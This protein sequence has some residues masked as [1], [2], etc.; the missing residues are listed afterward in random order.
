M[1]KIDFDRKK[2]KAL[3]SGDKLS[4]IREYF[5]IPN[6]AARFNKSWYTAKRLYA[7][8]PTGHFDIGLVGEIKNYLISKKQDSEIQ[9]TDE[10]LKE[11]N[12]KLDKPIIKRLKLDLRD[13]QEDT[14]SK[15]MTFGRGV[16]VLGT[17]AGKTLTIATL[18]E[19]F[20][21]YSKNVDN[22]KCLIVV[23]DLGLVN[24]TYSDFKEYNVSFNVTKWTGKIKP[25]FD[26]NVII[27]N[28]DILRSK[29]ELNPWIVDV[30]LLIIDEA[31][32]MGKGNK[33]SKL[34][35]KIK[36]SNRF[37]FTGTLPED[38]LDKWN[39][40]GKIG[41]VL[42]K[43]SSYELREENFLTN[44]TVNIFNLEY[45]TKP[46]RVKGSV[47]P[48]EN[49]RNELQFLSYNPFRNKV[50]QS[51]CNNFKNN[52]LILIN[53]IDHGQHLYDMLSSSL[54]DKQVFF[55]R[56]EVEVDE[57]DKVKRV[58]EEHN[59]VVCVAVSQ[60]F[61]TGVNIKNIHMILFAAGGKSFI[62][63]VQSIGRGLRLNDNKQE[64]KIIDLADNLEY[65]IDHSNK[66][67][68]IYNEE[69]ISYNIYDIQE[70]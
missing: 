64:L 62:R 39:I 29:F 34:L 66:R 35:D 68:M 16:C 9:I 51:T 37:G 17:G 18:I 60:I 12:P 5:S 61:S 55:I 70:K 11:L 50:I 45:K 10:A 25:D 46:I 20:Y 59:N 67:K 8:T 52:I 69:K 43:K 14:V 32:K 21:L 56:G 40:I 49:Y 2:N 33:S 15:C 26:A 4:E 57:R 30:N 41:P 6:P 23:P 58:M 28:I 31:H 3:I 44:V 48:T 42:I 54:K 19:N 7:I 38:N 63:T 36:T 27:A 13:Y 22:F 47:D 53:N 65:G 1:I 24:Q